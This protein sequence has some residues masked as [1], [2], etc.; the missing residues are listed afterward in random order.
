VTLSVPLYQSGSVYSKLR[1]A[2]QTASAT[3]MDL[4]QT[5]RDVT[6]QVR[7]AWETWLSTKARIEAI[8]TQVIAAET[9]LEGVQREASVGSRT[10]LDVLDAEQEMLDASVNLVK[11]QRDETVAELTLLSSIG[12]LTA[13]DLNLAV[14]LYDSQGHYQEVRDKWF[15]GSVN[16]DTAK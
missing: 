3:R 6:E 10:V 2:R 12:H 11:S 14:D 1:Q 4:V 16:D 9:A 13:T 7:S 5:R 8:K 15:G